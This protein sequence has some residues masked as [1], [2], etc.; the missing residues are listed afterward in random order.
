MVN[1]RL[2]QAVALFIAI[3]FVS[4]IFFFFPH[5]SSSAPVTYY[6][7]VPSNFLLS[8]SSYL[9][10][11]LSI[12]KGVTDDIISFSQAVPVSTL[13]ADN[14]SNMLEFT[15][16]MLSSENISY[17]TSNGNLLCIS[18]PKQFNSSLCANA[19]ESKSWGLFSVGSNGVLSSQQIPLSD[20][21]L[22]SIDSNTTYI[23]AFFAPVT[24]S[25]NTTTVPPIHIS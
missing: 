14:L 4:S 6:I 3:A 5:V 17:N 13:V 11:S 10:N 16:S 24:N 15:E 19:S 22:S 20:I 9:G 12:Q 8:N 1:V 21:K 18:S 23:L 7:I 25:S 2:K